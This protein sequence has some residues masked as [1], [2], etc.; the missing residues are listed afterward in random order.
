MLKMLSI[1]WLYVILLL[2]L[3]SDFKSKHI[4]IFVLNSL[5]TKVFYDKNSIVIYL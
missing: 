3:F 4:R 5:E 2:L 1:I